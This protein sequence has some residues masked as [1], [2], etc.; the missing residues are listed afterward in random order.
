M[1]YAWGGFTSIEEFRTGLTKG[2]FAGLV[3]ASERARASRHALGLDCSGYVARCFDLPVKQ[4]TRSLGDLCIEL[5]GYEALLPGDLLNKYDSHVALFI[6]WTDS[7]CRWMRVWEAARLGAKESVYDASKAKQE[8]FV[9][10]RYR[11][12][13]SHWQPM[14]DASLGAPTWRADPAAPAGKFSGS[15][16]EDVRLDDRP[17]GGSAA[18]AWVR[19]SV[20]EG[21]TAVSKRTLLA[22]T[23]GE[24]IGLQCV[25]DIGGKLLPTG[26]SVAK[27]QSL[28]EVLRDLLAFHE[29][30]DIRHV[31]EHTVERGS[32]ELGRRRF[33]AR[34]HTLKVVAETTVRH[35]THTAWLDITAILS[36]D[37]PLGRVVVAEFTLAIDWQM[38]GRREH[39]RRLDTTV[40]LE[41]FGAGR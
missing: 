39:A 26:R 3:P 33:S 16:I 5:D 11:L 41:A 18:G 9:P 4:T 37:V 40:V 1:P 28:P 25:E 32:W 12:L 13:D 24:N 34:R 38:R 36:D 23:V 22:A 30:L 6:D 21:G 10:L 14:D 35:Q 8:G 29:P 15:V 17:L 7:S 20:R 27:T 19:Y 31:A 2:L